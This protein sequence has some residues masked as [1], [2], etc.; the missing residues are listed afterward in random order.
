M[1][2]RVQTLKLK[3]KL[4]QCYHFNAVNDGDESEEGSDQEIKEIEVDA[5]QITTDKS[6]SGESEGD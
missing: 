3:G 4:D 5:A 6:K 1:E 2:Q